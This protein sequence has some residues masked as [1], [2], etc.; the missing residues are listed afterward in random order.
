V[1]FAGPSGAGKSTFAAFLTRRGYPLVTDDICLLSPSSD[2]EARVSPGFPQVKLWSDGVE[3]LQGDADL[4][5]RVRRKLDKYHVPITSGF[6]MRDLRLLRL[7]ILETPTA[8][9]PLVRLTGLDAVRAVAASTY[10]P[11]FVH[12][13]GKSAE[14][15]R[16]CA[17]VARQTQIY[18]MSRPLDF[19][20]L[21]ETLE[22]LEADWRLAS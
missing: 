21:E 8:R 20:Q 12:G 7:Y 3:Q 22:A 6:D 1:A 17:Q 10:R 19:A 13:M 16:A 14:H 18:H 11:A 5:L 2:G 15:F 9:A 4:L